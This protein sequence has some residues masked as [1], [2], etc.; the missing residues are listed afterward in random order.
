MLKY[1]RIAVTALSLTACVLLVALWVRSYF[2]MDLLEKKTNTQLFQINSQKGS[3]ALIEIDPGRNSRIQASDLAK[4]LAANSL[5]RSHVS[6]PIENKW[7][8]LSSLSIEVE[9][10][11]TRTKV[12]AP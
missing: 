11:T 4:I 10:K 8:S 2:Y 7:V 1:L 3:W 9:H 6:L 5:G 12:K